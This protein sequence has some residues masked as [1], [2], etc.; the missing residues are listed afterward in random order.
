MQKNYCNPQCFQGKSYKAKFS[1]R[2]IF[3]K[4]NEQRKFK[5]NHKKN[6]KGKKNKHGNTVAI[7]SVS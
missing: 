1:V 3:K 6:R 7:Y 4:L 2:L 5:K